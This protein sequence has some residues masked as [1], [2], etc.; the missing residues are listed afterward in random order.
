MKSTTVATERFIPTHRWMLGLVLVLSASQACADA[1]TPNNAALNAQRTRQHYA[2][3]VSANPLRVA[4]LMLFTNLMPKGGDLHHHYSGA[5][6]AE[7]YLDWVG[8]HNFCVYQ[9][10]D[11]ALQI[12]KFRIATQPDKLKPEARTQCLTAE[13]IKENN[14]FYRLLLQTWSDKDFDNHSHD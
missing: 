13:Q 6:Y 2:Q 5:I 9:Q 3:L 12:E 11:A 7:T 4:E 14:A 8:A 1:Q 10:S